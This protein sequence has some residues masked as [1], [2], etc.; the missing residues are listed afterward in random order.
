MFTTKSL[1]AEA[2]GAVGVLIG[3]T[4][5]KELN[6]MFGAAEEAQQISIPV[7]MLTLE[8]ADVLA[9][10][11]DSDSSSFTLKHTKVDSAM[12]S[13]V[14]KFSKWSEWPEDPEA[15]E[16]LWGKLQSIHDPERHEDGHHERIAILRSA[17]AAAEEKFSDLTMEV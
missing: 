12:W 14:S 11:V 16:N 6:R 17:H 2:A 9:E 3:N 5:P 4:A 10:K 7:A 15:R 1:N 8:A 13:Q